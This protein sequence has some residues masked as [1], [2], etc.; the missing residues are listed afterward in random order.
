MGGWHHDHNYENTGTYS[1]HRSTLITY[2]TPT[3]C[4]MCLG[5]FSGCRTGLG[6]CFWALQIDIYG[7][8]AAAGLGTGTGVR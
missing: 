2:A 6:L 4:T 8:R 1:R 5:T 3:Y 7:F